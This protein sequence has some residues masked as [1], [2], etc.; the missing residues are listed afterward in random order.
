VLS[1][2]IDIYYEVQLLLVF[3][4]V[5]PKFMGIRKV[6]QLLASNAHMVGPS[7]AKQFNALANILKEKGAQFYQTALK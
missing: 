1:F 7:V 5:C 4:L 6:Q 2:Y 3:Y